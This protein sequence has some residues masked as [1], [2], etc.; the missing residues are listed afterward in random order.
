MNGPDTQE[1]NWLDGTL[2]CTTTFWVKKTPNLLIIHLSL[3]KAGP[4]TLENYTHVKA[5]KMQGFS[6]I[7]CL[8]KSLFKKQHPNNFSRGYPMSGRDPQ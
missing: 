5:L 6:K 2:L 7:R 8:I 3:G 4:F 1:Y